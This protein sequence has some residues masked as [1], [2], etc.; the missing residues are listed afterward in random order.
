MSHDLTN[1]VATL[2]SVHLGEEERLLAA[3]LPIVCAVQAALAQ[4]T[5]SVLLEI[6][7][8]HRELTQ[9]IDDMV[10]RRQLLREQIARRFGLAAADVRLSQ[11]VQRMPA[12]LRDPLQSQLTRVRR[13]AN[14][15]VAT[16]H[17]LSLHVRIFLDAYQRLLRDLTAT[18]SGSGRY[19]P[20]GK[21]EMQVYR[22][23]LQIHG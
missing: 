7:R 23:L 10:R 8:D 21:S 17:R 1:D 6:V 13:M 3:A 22:P 20:Q 16:N 5:P 19:G 4:S 2:C 18:T 9:L 11:V 12:D 15:L 14:E